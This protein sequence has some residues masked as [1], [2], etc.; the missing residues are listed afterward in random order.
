MIE[1]LDVGWQLLLLWLANRHVRLSHFAVI[2]LV[3]ALVLTGLFVG[4]RDQIFVKVAHFLDLLA[5]QIELV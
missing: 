2:L 1:H 3:L 4:S 5:E